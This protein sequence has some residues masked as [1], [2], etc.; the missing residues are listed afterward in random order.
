LDIRTLLLLVALTTSAATAQMTGY[1]YLDDDGTM[2]LTSVSIKHGDAV[3]VYN[4]AKLIRAR[5][6]AYAGSGGSAGLIPSGAPVPSPGKRSEL[7][8]P[9]LNSG[10]INA[11]RAKQPEAPG[12]C[13]AFDTALPNRPGPDLVV[14]EIQT[15]AGN[16]PL[17]GDA[18]RLAARSKTGKVWS[19]EFKAFDVGFSHPAAQPVLTPQFLSAGSGA[20]VLRA[21]LTTSGGPSGMLFKVLG[22]AVDLSD[23]G[24][25]AD[26]AVTELTIQPGTGARAAVDPVCVAGLPSPDNTNLLAKAPPNTK[27]PPKPVLAPMLAGPL[28]DVADVVFAVRGPGTDHWY[29]NFGFYSEP[30]SEYPPQ[31]APG[32]KVKPRRIY[33]DGGQLARLNLRSRN[34]TILLDDPQGAVRDPVVGYDGETIFFSYRKGTSP[35]YHL[36]RIQADGTGLQ[37]LTDGP[38]NDIEP[39]CMPDGS[40]VFCS[41]RSK[42]YVNCWITPVATLHRCDRDGGNLRPL[43]SNIEHDNTPWPLPDGRFLYMRWEYVD[44]NQNVFHHLWTANPDGT[45]QM[46][47]FGNMHPGTAML[48]AKPVPGTREVVASFSPGHGRAEHAG[49]VTLVDPRMGPDYRPF[50]HRVS[51]GGP[52]YRDPYPISRNCFL[53]AADTRLLVMDGKG[54]T[55]V[56]HTLPK[57][58]K[59]VWL[60]EPRPLIPR[61]CEPVIA[62]RTQLED[63]QGTF[64]L[65]DIYVGRNLTG[66]QRGEVKELLVLEQLPKPVNF[67]G[68]MWPISAGGTFTLA[69]ILGTV[70]VREDGSAYFRAPVMRSLFFV[71]LDKDR[72]SVKRM[73]S[74]TTLQPGENMGCVGCHESRLT[75]PLAHNPRPDAMGREPDTIAAIPGIPAVPDFPRDVQ[76]ILDRHCVKCHNP[77]AFRARLDLTGDRTPLFSRAYWSLT[78]KGLYSDG[79]NSTRANFPPRQIGSG[80]SRILKYLDGSHHQ[81]K[82]TAE[83]RATVWAWIEAGAP[84]A[85]TYAALGSGM[86]PVVFPEKAIEKRCAS[87]HAEPTKRVIGGRKVGYRFGGKG[88]AL[89]LVNSFQ[90]LR[91]IRA[92][93]GYYKFGQSPTPQSLCN[94][95]RPEKSP[96]LLAHLAKEA[97]GWGLGA[98][99]VFDNTEDPDYQ[100]ILAAIQKASAKLVTVKRFDMPDFR[101]NDYYLYQMRRYGI[102]QPGVPENGYVL[103]RAY[104]DSFHYQP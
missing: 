64:F 69:R 17:G 15:D 9:I 31:R 61:P 3:R 73:H 7:L 20:D 25:P 86:S 18:F 39:S 10:L 8:D 55:E 85:G 42:R 28:K 22:T 35:F 37:Q 92:M 82:P 59:R 75:T 29:A 53:V 44:R 71:A 74:F 26:A 58:S 104:W 102:L 27:V 88:P 46:V 96:L 24:V 99:P 87:C 84:Y 89:P 68:G 62:A 21:P 1:S 76:P 43:S 101:P 6:T 2:S 14:F 19:A 23:L 78:Q 79:R 49:Y 33:K 66:L 4:A 67:S 103:D 54:R 45:G 16:S 51:R 13:L 65:G 52:I 94:L 63:A 83:E 57:S 32:G 97:G 90:N 95:D 41:D 36:H 12:L 77:D 56:V 72:R 30:G 40:L 91:D 98:E 11:S 34:V 93:V 60:H 100:A 48:D 5:V 50:A 80:N 38:F 47:Y 70:P 81:A